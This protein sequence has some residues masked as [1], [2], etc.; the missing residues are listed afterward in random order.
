VQR[1]SKPED[2]ESDEPSNPQILGLSAWLG[3][4]MMDLVV[5]HT[6]KNL[7]SALG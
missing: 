2:D 5:H 3:L 7:G 1:L 6:H 4:G